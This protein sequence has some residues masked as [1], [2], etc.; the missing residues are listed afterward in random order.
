LIGTA[1]LLAAGA[2]GKVPGIS[3]IVSRALQGIPGDRAWRWIFIVG[4][5]TG[6]WATFTFF[7]VTAQFRPVGSLALIAGAGVLVGLG[8]RL[9]GGCTSGHGVCGIGSG[10]KSSTLAVIVFMAT[11]VLVVFVLKHFSPSL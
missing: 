1:S 8:T 2:T 7:P 9:S 3:G 5:I 4:L 6:A 10:S 11:A